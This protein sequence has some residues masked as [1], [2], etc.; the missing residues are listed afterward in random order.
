MHI[1]KL[2]IRNTF[3]HKLRT[4]LTIIGIM[5]AILAFGLLR[6]VVSAWYSG[7]A[8]SS[9][10]RLVTRNAVS[11]I[12]S[13][14]VSYKERI[15]QVPGVTEVASGE[16]F[17]GVYISEKNFFPNFAVDAKTYLDLY[18]EFVLSEGQKKAFL[19]DRK[20]CVAGRKVAEQFGWKVG[21]SIVLKGTIFPG[22]WEF[23]L[24][25]I[26]HGQQKNTDETVFFFHWDYLNETLR[27]TAPLRADVAGYYIVGVKDPDR[28]AGVAVAIDALFKNS[29]AETLTETE[30]AF[31]LSFI[32]MSNAIIAVI[33]A[34]SIIV[35]IIIMAVMANTM[36][37]T[38]RERIGEYAVMKTLG[39]GA[40]HI[41]G[42]VFGESLI[43]SAIGCAAGIAF[44]YPAAQWFSDT[45]GIYVPVFNVENRTLLMDVA[46]ALIIGVVA[47]AFPTWRAI[48]VRIADGLR[49]IG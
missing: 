44:T 5:V 37:M 40:R 33:Q 43:I 30:K 38:A 41:A 47:A 11:L 31:Q 34:V 21:D 7:V 15:R 27:K 42:L 9:S 25:G 19:A 49:R 32:A 39:F 6:T 14:P 29:L 26:Y 46:A 24:R 16:W 28:A 1:L 2:L 23:V 10:T 13:L 17:G 48:N 36:A 8:A 4:G 20:G 22:N 3:R 35:I 12:F 45:M 18:P